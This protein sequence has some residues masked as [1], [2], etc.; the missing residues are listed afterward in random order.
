M[1]RP[2][3][4][5]GVS[6]QQSLTTVKGKPPGILASLSARWTAAGIAHGTGASDDDIAAFESRYGVV[7]PADLR[8]YFAT[9]NGT[10]VGAY[11]MQDEHLL[12]FWQLSEVQSFAE[13]LDGDR[14]TAPDTG[15]TFAIA[16]HSIW[17]Y[18]FGVQL[19]DNPG[20]PTPIVVDIGSPFHRVASS[21]TD[22]IAAYLRNDTDVLYPDPPSSPTGSNAPVV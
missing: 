1:D 19:S 21:F 15:R 17:V 22:F 3:L 13:I 5:Y 20:A 14:A 8:A 6:R 16:D 4:N 10:A 12:G 9:V 11:G 7:L 2:Q 18:G